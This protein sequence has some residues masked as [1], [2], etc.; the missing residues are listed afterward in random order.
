MANVNERVIYPT[1]ALWD[2]YSRKDFSFETID[3]TRSSWEDYKKIEKLDMLKK[4]PL[5][6]PH[7]YRKRELVEMDDITQLTTHIN[8]GPKGNEFDI[9]DLFLGVENQ[10]E[11]L[12]CTA[13]A[14]TSV[15]DYYNKRAF[16]EEKKSSKLFL[17]KTTRNFSNV[18]GNKPV[19]L[20]ATLGA[21]RLF[22]VPP[23][24]YLPKD[25][26]FDDEPSAYSYALAKEFETI[27]YFKI[28]SGK[29]HME[30]DLLVHRIKK[31]IDWMIPPMFTFTVYDH[32]FD[33]ET[34]QTGIIEN[35]GRA[36]NA[37]Y[38][39]AVVAVGYSDKGDPGSPE[40]YIKFRNSWGSDWGDKGYG[41][42]PYDYIHK[43]LAN[44]FW[45]ILD[46]EWVNTKKFGETD[47]NHA[48]PYQPE[49]I[50]EYKEIDESRVERDPNEPKKEY[51]RS[52]DRG[53]I[54]N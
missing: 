53:R 37:M 22:G 38:F 17:Y 42:L 28:N 6:A 45:V 1:G 35:V 48:D 43:R 8:D 30:R 20:R 41:Y 49:V 50:K 12:S 39:H 24:D 15:I 9:S 2:G 19:N 3:E 13:H 10:G 29:A 16:N 18:I 25:F 4:L 26:K 11:L 31:F 47:E 54:R 46:K 40:G 23:R 32:V 34:K 33:P 27:R 52:E 36:D 14:A 7:I 21:M 44:N 51:T 5:Y